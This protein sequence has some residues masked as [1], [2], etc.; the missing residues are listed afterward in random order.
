MAVDA[1]S[2]GKPAFAAFLENSPSI[3]DTTDPIQCGNARRYFG[4]RANFINDSGICMDIKQLNSSP[5][6]KFL[7]TFFN[8]GGENGSGGSEETPFAQVTMPPFVLEK[9]DRSKCS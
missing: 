3:T 2:S 5:D 9:I 8:Q 4:F 6:F 7:D 1:I